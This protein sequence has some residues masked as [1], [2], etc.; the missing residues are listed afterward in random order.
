MS[1]YYVPGNMQDTRRYHFILSTA[2][3]SQYYYS[4]LLEE[5]INDLQ[6]H[7]SREWQSW[8]TNLGLSGSDTQALTNHTQ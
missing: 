7:L 8:H 3:Y 4:H 1:T 5:E 6:S 2:L